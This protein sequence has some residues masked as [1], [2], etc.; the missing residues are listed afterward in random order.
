MRITDNNQSA[1]ARSRRQ[2]QRQERQALPARSPR[3]VPGG[4][5]GWSETNTRSRKPCT[6]TLR[7]GVFCCP[8]F[9]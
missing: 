5:F 8:N 6:S 3:S 4:W 9:H 7:C 2:Q 1:R